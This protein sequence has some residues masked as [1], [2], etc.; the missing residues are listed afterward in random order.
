MAKI[1]DS[2]KLKSYFWIYAPVDDIILDNG[3]FIDSITEG[4]PD[5]NKETIRKVSSED[6]HV[7][8]AEQDKPRK[9]NPIFPKQPIKSNRQVDDIIQTIRSEILGNDGPLV[10]QGQGL[11]VVLAASQVH[12][13][14]AFNDR[15][16]AQFSDFHESLAR[17]LSNH[18]FVDFRKTNR[19]AHVL[20]ASASTKADWLKA[21]DPHEYKRRMQ[22]RF[23]S[24]STKPIKFD[25]LVLGQSHYSS[26]GFRVQ[27]S[28]RIVAKIHS[29]G[30]IDRLCANPFDN[31]AADEHINRVA[32]EARKKHQQR[33]ERQKN[34]GYLAY[35]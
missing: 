25:H 3:R 34:Q 1:W 31:N 17:S 27:N 6:W 28:D 18:G 2:R 8:I 15:S 33:K 12:L 35:A 23:K 4:H 21:A 24:L 22:E 7:T 32:I 14:L 26:E 5:F 19:S 16:K 20:L 29:D 9:N 13:T 30:H 10:L 11:D